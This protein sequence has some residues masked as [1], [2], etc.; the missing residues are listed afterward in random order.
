MPT[1]SAP[2]S[3]IPH[4]ASAPIVRRSGKG[5]TDLFALIALVLF[6]ASIALAVGMFLYKEYLG[7]S[8]ASKVDQLERA[9]AAFEP[10]LIN[11]L[12]RLDDRMQ[13]AGEILQKHIAPSVFFQMLEQTTINSVAFTSLDFEVT[14]AEN[15]AI[16][17]DG[18][19]GSV[20][21]IALQADLFSKGGMLTSPIFSNINREVDGVHFS[22]SANVNPLGINF[23]Q[24]ISAPSAIA[25]SPQ[26]LPFGVPVEP[27]P[28]DTGAAQDE[29][30]L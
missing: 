19:A 6:V 4:E 30:S 26:A 2:Q 14:D 28:E 29:T 18:L 5:L 13:A 17:M 1:Q 16:R 12:T 27:Q 3:F 10:S 15:M 24:L 20:N 9:K 25:P 22:L 11:E 7:S 8:T 23:A 21:G